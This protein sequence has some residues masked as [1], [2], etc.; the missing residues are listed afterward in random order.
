MIGGESLIAA[1]IATACTVVARPA[2]GDVTAARAWRDGVATVLVR[3]WSGAGGVSERYASVVQ[4]LYKR[5]TPGAGLEAELQL[6]L[7]AA[8]EEGRG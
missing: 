6:R 3:D 8:A 4:A 7:G 2:G 1:I 5:C